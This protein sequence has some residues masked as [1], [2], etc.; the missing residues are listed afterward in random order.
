MLRCVIPNDGLQFALSVR[1]T[2][3]DPTTDRC[4]ADTDQGGLLCVIVLIVLAHN[5]C[6]S[7]M[8]LFASN[9]DMNMI[10]INR[11]H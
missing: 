3:Y 7:I 4:G 8:Q 11:I 6:V 10:S 1:M 2:H 9:C 5:V